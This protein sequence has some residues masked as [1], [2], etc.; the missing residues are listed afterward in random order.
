MLAKALDDAAQALVAEARTAGKFST[1]APC[2]NTT[3]RRG[4]REDV[5]H[6]VRRARRTGARVATAEMTDLVALYHARRR[7]PAART[8]R[9]STWSRARSCSRRGSS[10]SPQL[11]TRR[12]SGDVHADAATSWRASCRTS[13]LAGRPTD[14]ARRR[15]RAGSLATADGRETQAR[16][17]LATPA[18]RRSHGARRARV[19]RRRRASPETAKDT[20]VYTRLRRRGAHVDGHRERGSSSTRSLQ[21]STGTVGELLSANWSIVDSTLAADLRRDLGGRD[22]AHDRCPKRRGI[23]NQARVPVGVRARAARRRPC[24]A[25]WRSC[26]GSPASRCR[27]PQSLNIEVVPPA[28]DPAK[29]TRE[30]FEIHAT[31]AAC[32]TCHSDA[33]TRSASRSRGSTAWASSARKDDAGTYKDD[34]GRP[35]RPAST[36]IPARTDF[37]ATSTGP[38]PTA[39]RWRP[40]WPTARRCASAWRARCSARRRR[41]A[42]TTIGRRAPRRRSSTCWKQMP[43]AQQGKF[44]E[45]L[46]AYVRSPL[47]D[48]RSAP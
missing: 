14:A 27:I 33:S 28:P 2:A 9:A 6:V 13:S 24:C 42:A 3:G 10:T 47:F 15:R 8:T 22:R 41:R 34:A 23:L 32:A 11:G 26:A 21:R 43:A 45:M 38:T 4:L 44:I 36:T 37:R 18:G 5:H 7:Q 46:V 1:L 19:A 25:A 40:R 29:T 20:T 17:L 31:D 30:R 12:S 39:T 48:Q 35:R 16:R